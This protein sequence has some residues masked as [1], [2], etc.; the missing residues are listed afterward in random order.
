[1][2][3][4]NTSPMDAC[5]LARRSENIS[6][7]FGQYLCEGA[8]THAAVDVESGSQRCKK[9]TSSDRQQHSLDQSLFTSSEL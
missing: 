9:T 7:L 1:M 3:I 8:V 4:D 5:E 2:S 6:P